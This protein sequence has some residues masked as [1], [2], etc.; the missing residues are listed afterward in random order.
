[1]V[2]TRTPGVLFLCSKSIEKKSGIKISTILTKLRS[3]EMKK[4]AIGLFLALFLAFA[5]IGCGGEDVITYVYSFPGLT[6][7]PDLSLQAL[8]DK[9]GGVQFQNHAARSLRFFDDGTFQSTTIGLGPALGAAA[10]WGN[11]YRIEG[12]TIYFYVY[13]STTPRHSW[14]FELN[15]HTLIF[16]GNHAGASEALP[17]AT[18]PMTRVIM[19]YTVDA[20]GDHIITSTG[21]TVP[22][23][24]SFGIIPNFRF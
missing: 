17:N 8:I 23:E 10:T 12:N 21:V 6:A 22:V 9:H 20:D 11:R 15:G 16:T 24:Y 5:M 14:D 2:S 4:K 18:M 3:F 1:M 7:V 19:T 13:P